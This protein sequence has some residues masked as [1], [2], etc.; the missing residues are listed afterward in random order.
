MF[1]ISTAKLGPFNVH[2]VLNKFAIFAIF[3]DDVDGTR[4]LHCGATWNGSV[5]LRHD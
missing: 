3:A 4:P 1:R 5:K 2:Y